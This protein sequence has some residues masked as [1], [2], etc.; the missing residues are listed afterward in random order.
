MLTESDTVVATICVELAAVTDRLAPVTAVE[1]ATLAA[2]VLP[3]VFLTT[4]SAAATETEIAD[5]ATLIEAD[6]AVAVIDEDSDALTVTAPAPALIEPPS[7]RAIAESCTE[8]KTF[9]PA[10]LSATPTPPGLIAT[11]RLAATAV[12]TIVAWSVAV[13]DTELAATVL[14]AVVALTDVAMSLVATAP[15]RATAPAIPP[16]GEAATAI[17]TPT[18]VATIVAVFEALTRTAP[19]TVT[20]AWSTV[21]VTLSA[22]V[23]SATDAL[24]LIAIAAPAFGDAATLTDSDTVVATICAESEAV[25]A[26]LAPVTEVGLITVAATVLPIVFLTTLSAPATEIETTDT[27]T[28]TDADTAVPTIEDS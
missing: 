15:A 28:L 6:M 12:A 5:T 1:F 16:V 14:D 23:L 8:L 7:M 21:A 10:M 24:R 27:A 2:T 18:G 20:G 3:V 26:R 19:V 25:T 13:T 4:L 9:A 17:A 11:L 22:T